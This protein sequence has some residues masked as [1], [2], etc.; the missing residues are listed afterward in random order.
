MNKSIRT[1]WTKKFQG[2]AQQ[3]VPWKRDQVPSH[4]AKD[5]LELFA[6][7]ELV[8]T[9]VEDSR[10]WYRAMTPVRW[11]K[12]LGTFIWLHKG[13]VT[14]GSF[15]GMSVWGTVGYMR[16]SVAED[17][18]LNLR[19]QFYN[20]SEVCSNIYSCSNQS[21]PYVVSTVQTFYGEK[22]SPFRYKSQ[23][24]SPS[25]WQIQIQTTQSLT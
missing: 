20:S 9:L 2:Y 22:K 25:H 8:R 12:R 21:P 3:I 11:I 5:Q 1:H 18:A 16:D 19:F 15:I 7:I 14:L 17:A 4:T 24:S 6:Q 23:Q 10:W 13:K